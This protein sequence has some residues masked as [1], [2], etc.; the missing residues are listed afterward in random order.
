MSLLMFVADY[1]ALFRAEKYIASGMAAVLLATIPL[2][3]LVMEMILLPRHRLSAMAV[4]STLMGFAGVIVL[5]LPGTHAGLQM[6]PCLAILAGATAWALGIVLSRSMDLPKARPMTSGAT[7]LLGGA[8]LLALSA[9][10]GELRGPL[11]ISL[12]ALLAEGYLIVFGSLIAF[13]AFVWLLAHMPATSVSSYAYVNPIVAVALGYFLGGE[14]ITLRTLAGTALVVA[15]VVL[16][17][18]PIKHAP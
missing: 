1:A 13:T 16:I 14:T 7:M 11:H 5:L 6:L 17:L 3:T 4:G 8:I 9:A 10:T 2:L 15:S 12:R 18:R